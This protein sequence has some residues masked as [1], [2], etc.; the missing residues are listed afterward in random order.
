MS[1]AR[2][3]MKVGHS[4]AVALPKSVCQALQMLPGT[5]LFVDVVG[6]TIVLSKAVSTLHLQLTGK[7]IPKDEH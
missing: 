3:V 1:D 4:W 7:E 2:R 5:I 6:D